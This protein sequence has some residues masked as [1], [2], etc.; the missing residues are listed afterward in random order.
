MSRAAPPDFHE[1]VSQMMLAAP[2]F[3]PL[4]FMTHGINDRGSE[5]YSSQTGQLGHHS[6]SVGILDIES[7]GR[8]TIYHSTS[9]RHRW[10]MVRELGEISHLALPASPTPYCISTRL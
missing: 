8:T 9:V 4:E 5:R 3:L 10:G 7:H 6:M 2:L 1:P